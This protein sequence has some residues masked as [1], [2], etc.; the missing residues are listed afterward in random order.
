MDSTI[1]EPVL[2]FIS[3]IFLLALAAP[4]MAGKKQG[5][6]AP[7]HVALNAIPVCYDFGCKNSAVVDLPV[8]E[9]RGVEDWFSPGA[10]T[11]E[12]ERQQIK[13][14]IGWMEVLIGR[15]TPTHKDL[16]FNLPVGQVDLTGLF[17]GQ[18]DCIDEAVNTTTYLRLIEQKG[19]LRHHTVI[20]QAYRKALWDQHWAGQIREIDSGN[21]YVVDS[22][23]QPNGYLPVIQNSPDWN[24]IT[25]LSALVDNSPRIGDE[26]PDAEQDAPAVKKDR[27]GLSCQGANSKTK[28]QGRK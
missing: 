23:F 25:P 11:P 27:C 7:A 12:Q 20:K 16:A 14:A 22:W 15:H 17:P 19:L 26:N 2:R 5:I 13:Q 24:N 3:V 8:V 4:A 6:E 21:Q 9:W 10:Q 18:L 1:R 28:I